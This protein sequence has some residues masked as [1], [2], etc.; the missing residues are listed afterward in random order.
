[1]PF[2]TL[3][4]QSDVHKKVSHN[5]NQSHMGA[6]N[7]IRARLSRLQNVLVWGTECCI[8]RCGIAAVNY[9]PLTTIG[10][11]SDH[12][13]KAVKVDNVIGLL[14]VVQDQ[15]IRVANSIDPP[16]ESEEEGPRFG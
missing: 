13:M 8:R 5:T 4:R 1:M 15:P 6:E 14:P 12:A 10:N 7:K 3:D 11:A 16:N 9:R 2:R